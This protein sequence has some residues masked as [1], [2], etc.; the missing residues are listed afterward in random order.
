M[1]SSDFSMSSLDM[2]AGGGA[3]APWRG[4]LARPA[5]EPVP[6]PARAIAPGE[7][8]ERE[9]RGRTRGGAP[10]AQ[11]CHG[12]GEA[13]RATQAAAGCGLPSPPLCSPLWRGASFSGMPAYA[14]R[15]ATPALHSSGPYSDS[16][17]GICGRAR[18]PRGRG[19]RATG[20]R[21]RRGEQAAPC[22]AAGTRY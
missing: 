15:L 17:M 14:M 3:Y 4:P 13:E 22:T 19:A 7:D 5:G 6:S 1:R 18:G 12:H 16:M 10:L 20:K 11:R 8:K 2:A 9:W 21:A